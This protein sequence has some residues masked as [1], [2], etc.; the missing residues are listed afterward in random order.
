VFYDSLEVERLYLGK[1][2]RTYTL[3]FTLNTEPRLI[4]YFQAVTGKPGSTAPILGGL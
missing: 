2:S 1:L 4:E 3:L